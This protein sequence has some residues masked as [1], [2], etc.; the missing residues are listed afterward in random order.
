MSGGMPVHRVVALVFADVP[1]VDARDAANRLVAAVGSRL[2]DRLPTPGPRSG[3]AADIRVRD[4][5][6]LSVATGTPGYLVVRPASR[7]P[8]EPRTGA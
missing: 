1:G 6:D 2:G 8:H 5:V 3:R 4:V 7:L